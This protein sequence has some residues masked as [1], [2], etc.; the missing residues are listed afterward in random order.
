VEFR[1]DAYFRRILCESRRDSASFVIYTIFLHDLPERRV[2]KRTTDFVFCRRDI[3]NLIYWLRRVLRVCFGFVGARDRG[4][5]ETS[6]R[7]FGGGLHVPPRQFDPEGSKS[8]SSCCGLLNG[9]IIT[10]CRRTRRTGLH[11]HLYAPPGTRTSGNQ[12]STRNAIPRPAV[13]RN[14]N[15]FVYASFKRAESSD[16]VRRRRNER[17]NTEE[18]TK[19]PVNALSGGERAAADRERRARNGVLFKTG[20]QFT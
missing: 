5:N 9:L 6:A 16:V 15:K 8:R 14:R 20:S 19:Y 17:V 7:R 13:V 18:I 3:W 11:L 1:L 12:K 4:E 2:T 10:D